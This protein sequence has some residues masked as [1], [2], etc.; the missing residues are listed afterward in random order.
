[1]ASGSDRNPIKRI[2]ANSIKTTTL[3][4]FVMF[5]MIL[6]S[7]L[8]VLTSFFLD[9]YYQRVR[10]QEVIRTASSIE[11]QYRRSPSNFSDYAVETADINGIYI[12]ID[13]GASTVIFDGTRTGLTPDDYEKDIARIKKKLQSNTS[14][15][16]TETMH[17]ASSDSNA[18]LVYAS[19]IRRCTLTRLRSGSSKV[20]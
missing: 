5:A 7:F 8:W 18:R 1:M 10:T 20:C 17:T 11:T 14:E 3:F 16:V 4:S 19:V 12:R 15:S 2:D 13:D 9:T 6:I